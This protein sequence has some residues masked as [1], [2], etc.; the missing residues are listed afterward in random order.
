MNAQDEED[1]QG[2]TMDNIEDYNYSPVENEYI[3]VIDLRRDDASIGE[4]EILQGT[5]R[6]ICLQ[7][8]G[9]Y[10]AISYAFEGQKKFP[11]YFG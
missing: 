2:L 5:L 6:T 11:L 1:V 10:D 9:T 4:E 7:R 3:R 8:A